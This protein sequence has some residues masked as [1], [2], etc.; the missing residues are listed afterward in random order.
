MDRTTDREIDRPH[1]FHAYV[2][3]AQARPN[4]KLQIIVVA[5]H[6]NLD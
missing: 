6:A 1:K 4:Y 2:G 5:V 3:L